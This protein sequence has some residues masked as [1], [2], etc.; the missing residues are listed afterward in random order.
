MI[1][2]KRQVSSRIYDQR[3]VLEVDT[4]GGGQE[5]IEWEL[6]IVAL[7]LRMRRSRQIDNLF[8]C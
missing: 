6:W 4:V 5:L 3:K 7:Y 8:Y 2:L 1:E